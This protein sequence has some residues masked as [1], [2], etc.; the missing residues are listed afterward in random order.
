VSLCYVEKY[1]ISKIAKI[2]LYLT[3]RRRFTSN[4]HKIRNKLNVLLHEYM[5]KDVYDTH[6]LHVIDDAQLMTESVIDDAL[7]QA[8]MYQAY[9]D[10]VLW[11]YEILSG[12]LA[13]TFLYGLL[14]AHDIDI[15]LF[16]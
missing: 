3:Q 14:W 9:A 6:Q 1:K 11:R 7:L 12:I 8:M 2:L 13:V 16:I 10:S 4:F 15:H 5:Q